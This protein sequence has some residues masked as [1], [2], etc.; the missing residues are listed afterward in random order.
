MLNNATRWNYANV[1]CKKV[2]NIKLKKF[3]LK[4]IKN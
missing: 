3:K 4:Q 2:I 1:Q